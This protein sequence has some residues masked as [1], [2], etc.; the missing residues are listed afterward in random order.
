MI[1]LGLLKEE[2]LRAYPGDTQRI[3]AGFQQ[4][5]PVIVRRKGKD[6]RAGTQQTDE[7]GRHLTRVSIM[8]DLRAAVLN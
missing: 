8:Q 6:T 1:F 7:V 4:I 5:S 2:G 3:S